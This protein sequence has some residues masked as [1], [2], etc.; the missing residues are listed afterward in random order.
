ME[1]VKTIL[2]AETARKLT[3]ENET[4]VFSKVIDLIEIEI[5]QAISEGIYMASIDVSH[6]SF[7]VLDEVKSYLKDLGYDVGEDYD[8]GLC[9]NISWR[10]EDE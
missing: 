10:K 6:L 5:K 7:D 3:K 9:L 2:N 8:Y 1:M 4:S